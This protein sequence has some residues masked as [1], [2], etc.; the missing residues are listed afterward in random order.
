MKLEGEIENNGIPVD[1][2][3]IVLESGDGKRNGQI[4]CSWFFFCFGKTDL[5]VFGYY[6]LW[7]SW[8]VPAELNAERL[9][10]EYS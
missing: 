10:T 7:T 9:V 2:L 1:G 8:P 3:D 6:C 5:F 4:Q